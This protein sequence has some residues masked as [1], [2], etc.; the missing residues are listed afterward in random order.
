MNAKRTPVLKNTSIKRR[1]EKF[2]HLRLKKS[3]NY[4]SHRQRGNGTP[5]MES[6]KPF[7]SISFKD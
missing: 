5:T 7:T 6:D 3:R 2:Q 4:D 1:K